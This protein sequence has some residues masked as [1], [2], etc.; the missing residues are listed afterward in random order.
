[1][2]G[3]FFFYVSI[4]LY[5]EVVLS[6]KFCKR[7]SQIYSNHINTELTHCPGQFFHR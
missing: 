7:Q 4:S 1:M 5:S 6:K 2:F 3:N